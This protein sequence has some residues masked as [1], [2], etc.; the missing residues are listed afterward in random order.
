MAG[1][2]H[3]QSLPAIAGRQRSL[4]PLPPLLPTPAMLRRRLAGVA[5]GARSPVGR[6]ERD[7]RTARQLHR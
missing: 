6:G 5:G 2:G 1:N 7:R 4:P 3:R